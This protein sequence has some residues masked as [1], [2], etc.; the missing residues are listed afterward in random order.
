MT[1]FI[2]YLVWAYY[3]STFVDNAMF[4]V[5]H[6]YGW[7]KSFHSVSHNQA[8]SHFPSHVALVLILQ[9]A[10]SLMLFANINYAIDDVLNEL[11]NGN[12]QTVG[13]LL[14]TLYGQSNSTQDLIIGNT[15]IVLNTTQISN[16]TYLNTTLNKL[17]HQETSFLVF[18]TLEQVFDSYSIAVP[19]DYVDLLNQLLDGQAPDD[20]ETYKNLIWILNS[21]FDYSTLFYLISCVICIV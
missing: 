17:S 7:V 3:F 5:H 19:S 6:A 16:A 1:C 15:T 13:N 10:N 14:Y 12:V 21:K 8:Y 18:D 11:F 4:N 20:T 2:I 9:L